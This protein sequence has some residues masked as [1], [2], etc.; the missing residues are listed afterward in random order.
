MLCLKFL[1]QTLYPSKNLSLGLVNGR[2]KF[3]NLILIQLS[4]VESTATEFRRGQIAYFVSFCN[5]FLAAANFLF[6]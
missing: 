2:R 3:A 6:I 5:A 1:H 4:G